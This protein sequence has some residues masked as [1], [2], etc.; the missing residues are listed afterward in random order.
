[1]L[2]LF[3]AAALLAR[4]RFATLRLGGWALAGLGGMLTATL[5][6][7][8]LD[9]H[10]AA[11]SGPLA[12]IT[13]LAIIVAVVSAS[14][15]PVR[16]QLTDA[17]L[18]LGAL[19]A[20]SAWVGVAFHVRPFGHPDGGLWRAATTVTYANAAAAILG[21][22][23]L[24]ALA[25][26]AT[27]HDWTSR[28]TAVLLLAGLGATLSRAGLASFVVGLVVLSALLGFGVLWRS[29]GTVVLG[30]LIATVALAPG[31]P[32][33]SA[34]KPLWALL[35][36]AV[37]LATGLVRAP[38]VLDPRRSAGSR[39]RELR[40]GWLALLAALAVGVAVVGLSGHA[41]AW[42]GR[43]S[44][45]SPDRS[46]LASAAMHLW[47]NH[48]LTGV[49]PG[50]ALFV[51][52][53][54]YHVLLFDRY[55]HNEYLQVAVEQGVVG[56]IAL[57]ALVAAIGATAFG[58]WRAGSRSRSHDDATAATDLKAIRAGAIA[59]LICVAVHS[60][61]DFLWHVPAVPMLAALAVGL[62]ARLET[63]ALSQPHTQE[64]TQ[65]VS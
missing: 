65:E 35:G 53:T 17:T 26:A 40:I 11:A 31:M 30:G 32:D 54:P 3:A 45:S 21:P 50:R 25:Q 47:H 34:A 36:L 51:W 62:T 29:V 14:T 41:P 49:G 58:G 13:G 2:L 60:G 27:R 5:V 28:A 57:G 16:R 22:L 12:L 43:F 10:L 39:V 7:G 52:T 44:L 24:W 8:L 23:A 64:Q 19:L 9:G 61:F 46:S 63:E 33:T 42:S 15:F 37:G 6:T 20:A 4:R 56:L 18:A 55:A 59:G 38:G 1:V 48:R